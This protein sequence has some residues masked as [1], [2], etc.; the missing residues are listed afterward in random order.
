MAAINNGVS[1]SYSLIKIASLH[2]ESLTYL[3]SYKS[4]KRLGIEIPESLKPKT[5]DSTNSLADRLQDE[6]TKQSTLKD[7]EFARLKLQQL[8]KLYQFY[9]QLGGVTGFG[10]ILDVDR[11]VSDV[12]GQIKGSLGNYNLSGSYK[13][14]LSSNLLSQSRS[15]VRIRT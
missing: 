15:S 2:T 11:Q 10:G 6:G 3:R 9:S 5:Q 4:L 12:V 1:D 7:L 8:D 14:T 13:S